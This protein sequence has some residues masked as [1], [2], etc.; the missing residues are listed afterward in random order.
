MTH[1]DGLLHKQVR[2]RILNRLHVEQLLCQVCHQPIE[3]GDLY[4]VC[5]PPPEHQ[6][7][8]SRVFPGKIWHSQCWQKLY[9]DW[10]SS[11]ISFDVSY[12]R[13]LYPG[14]PSSEKSIGVVWHK[15][16]KTV[17]ISWPSNLSLCLGWVIWLKILTLS[18][19]LAIRWRSC[20]RGFPNAF[21]LCSN[22]S[23]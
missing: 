7:K 20:S 23:P 17:W 19:T 10:W 15:P 2:T 1:S 9:M 18:R 8:C 22:N 3:L 5:Y 11:R 4:H 21:M 13:I 16:V 12:R 14:K 6:R